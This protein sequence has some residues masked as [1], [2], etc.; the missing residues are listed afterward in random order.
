M[1]KIPVM[2]L[3]SFPTPD[4]RSHTLSPSLIRFVTTHTVHPCANKFRTIYWRRGTDK[5]VILNCYCVCRQTWCTHWGRVQRWEPLERC[6]GERSHLPNPRYAL[7]LR[8]SFMGVCLFCVNLPLSPTLQHQCILLRDYISTV[9]GP[10]IRSLRSNTRRCSL[11]LCRGNGRCLRKHPGSG[12]MFSDPDET[13]L[14]TDSP[15]GEPFHN[16]FMCQCYQGWAGQECQERKDSP[17]RPL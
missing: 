11:Q 12:H 16:H 2:P 9:L 3:R 15:R 17:D 8:E 7:F 5:H 13:N 4:W 10:F 6:C 1:V 14:L